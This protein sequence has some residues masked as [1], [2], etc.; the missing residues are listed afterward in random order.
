MRNLTLSTD[1]AAAAIG[2]LA[3]AILAGLV[4]AYGA[5][6]GPP[7]IEVSSATDLAALFESRGYA[8]PLPAAGPVPRLLLAALPGDLDRIGIPAERKALFLRIMLPLVLTVNEEIAA[9]RAQL[10]AL[11][12]RIA[13]G[14]PLTGEQADVLAMLA[15]RYRVRPGGDPARDVAQL[16]AK[17]DAVPPSLAAAQAALE[18][19]WGTSRLAREGNALFG[20]RTWTE[21]G[22]EPLQP[23]PGAR[24]RARSFDGLLDAV[25]SYA[26]NLNS[27]P[28]Y[29]GFRRAR[30]AARSAGRPSDGAALAGHLTRYSELGAAYTEALRRLIRANRL[31][32]LDRAALQPGSAAL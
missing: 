10:L 32:R 25:R 7:A 20:E 30:A 8:A 23:L 18:S 6:S 22:L 31:D 26:L 3:A 14:A 2:G 17:V 5:R 28:A 9:E 15:H 13:G 24:H 11:A 19:G 1:L 12:D 29:D 27:H 4:L 16:L 21:A